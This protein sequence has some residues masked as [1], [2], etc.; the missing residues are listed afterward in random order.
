MLERIESVP[1]WPLALVLTLAAASACDEAPPPTPTPPAG[2]AA[3][4]PPGPPPPRIDP[5]PMPAY[6]SLTAGRAVV[7]SR[8]LVELSDTGPRIGADSAVIRLT[9]EDAL[10]KDGAGVDGAGVDLD[11]TLTRVDGRWRSAA[12]AA[13]KFNQAEHRV[14]P[15]GL[16]I[17]G[18]RLTGTVKVEVMPDRWVPADGQALDV[19]A[20]LD[21][22]V[23]TDTIGPR[24][25]YED[26]TG[27]R[28]W[29]V[30]PEAQPQERKVTG[31][32]TATVGGPGGAAAERAGG[33][34]GGAAPAPRP[35]RWDMGRATADGLRLA[36]DL[37]DRRQNW[38]HARLAVLDLRGDRDLTRWDGLRVAVTT[39]EPRLDAEVSVWL[40]EQ[41]GSWYYRKSA[42]P[43][44]RERN[45]AVLWFE[46][47][48]EA[49]WV[50]PTNHMDE[51]YVFDRSGVSHIGIGVVNPLG[52]GGVTFTV[53]GLEL[54]RHQP[55]DTAAARAVVTGATL[56]VNGHDVVPAG[57]FGGYAPSLPQRFRP[58]CQRFL[59]AGHHPRIPRKDLAVPGAGDIADWPG[60]LALLTAD[61]PERPAIAHAR[62]VIGEL[63]PRLR[64]INVAEHR[65]RLADR[66]RDAGLP[67]KHLL[68][69]LEALVRSDVLY[70]AEAWS[71]VELSAAVRQRVDARASLNTTERVELNRRLLEALLA[72]HLRPMPAHGPHE[73]FY[74]D[75]LGERYEPAWVLHSPNWET[76]LRR[77]GRAFGENAKAAGY[78]DAVLEFWNEPYLN[79]A[80]RSRKNL[81]SKFYDTANAVEGGDVQVKYK[82]GS[83][84]PVVPHFTWAKKG[85]K[86]RVV[87]TTAFSYWSGRGNGWLYDQMLGALGPAL[88]AAYPEVT[89]VAGWGFRWHEDHW[90]AW[91]MLYKPTIDRNID[92]IDGIHEHHY[93]GDTTAL[94]GSYEVLA[95]YG[96]TAHDKWLHSYNTETN[97][98]VDAP[99][100]GRIDTPEDVDA[101]KQ[102]RRM[103][104]N[105]RDLVYCVLQSPDKLMAR[106]V[107]HWSHTP[108]GMDACYGSLKDLRGR[109]IEAGSD[110]PDLW[111]VASVDGTD[112]KA[113]PIDGGRSLV[114]AV[115]NDHR[116]A[117]TAELDIQAPHGT[118]LGEGQAVVP[119]FDFESLAVRTDV[120]AVTPDAPEA[121]RVT[122]TLPPRS[123]WTVR[124]ALEGDALPAASHVQ[125]SQ[126]FAPAL[127]RHARPGQPVQTTAALPADRLAAASRAWLRLVVED[128]DPGEATVTIADGEPQPLPAAPT[129]DN[130]NRIIEIP[131]PLDALAETVPLRFGVNDPSGGAG[132]RIA[133][134]SIVL[135][136]RPGR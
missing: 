105:F 37:G 49:E 95:A 135:E 21:A 131:I 30:F 3:A 91:D 102:Y 10:P 18:D 2:H 40:R 75:C 82:D 17:E 94:N 64:R 39:D 115:F 106:T 68:K 103:T 84:G 63:L 99:A 80:E 119:A 65:E 81:D 71:A 47:F 107:I 121:H 29:T 127:L 125:R 98:L 25:E 44:A 33:V 59:Y 134:A 79:W 41:D 57:I 100:R 96:R 92:S 26:V 13:P 45:E 113:M 58:G 35:G 27:M 50:A 114:V 129:A 51:D 136:S 61:A 111:V 93:Q 67:P 8:P 62:R 53:A 1:R 7:A 83:L 130:G 109:L 89:L 88:K 38:N 126:H 24:A 117:R 76:R 116:T 34:R 12:A 128:I 42:V 9:L 104:Y 73:A 122:L 72:P 46:D 132:Y 74:V 23:S 78:D 28:F 48:A 14:D 90:A 20:E 5:P 85:G 120:A 52:V 108:A 16:A 55:V 101:V 56:A 110:D 133:M 66:D 86:L 36:F 15:A 77:F 124:F 11:L 4:E 123:G 32:Y 31:S 97:D 87:D 54:V 60:L 118:T 112:P 22:K 70:E 69:A 43:L 19:V 6:P